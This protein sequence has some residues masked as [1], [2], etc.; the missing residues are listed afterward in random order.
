MSTALAASRAG[1]S[2]LLISRDLP[3]TEVSTRLTAMASGVPIGVL[4][5]GA[6]AEKH[7]R[8]VTAAFDQHCPLV[9]ADQW[10]GPFRTW[11]SYVREGMPQPDLVIVDGGAP[12]E[13]WPEGTSA[14]GA[15]CK[16]EPA[17]IVSSRAQHQ[18]VTTKS[19]GVGA[20]VH[21]GLDTVGRVTADADTIE[22]RAIVSQN[23]YGPCGTAA[24]ILRPDRMILTP[25]AIA[26]RAPG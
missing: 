1:W 16:S 17:V 8:A 9:V 25:A 4:R 2:T 3:L 12:D 18:S 23:R 19:E 5:S 10:R 11:A 15:S 21:I 14:V 22:I 7:W 13:P 26:A 20:D 6:L 24:L